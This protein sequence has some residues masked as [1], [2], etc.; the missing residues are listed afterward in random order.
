MAG[1]R[2]VFINKYEKEFTSILCIHYVHIYNFLFHT[3][4]NLNILKKIYDINIRTR[5]FL[6]RLVT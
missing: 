4:E 5:I 6:H 1:A 2:S 3:I